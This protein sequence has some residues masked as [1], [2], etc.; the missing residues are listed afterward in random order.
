MIITKMQGAGNDFVIINNM[1]EHL[2]LEG[3]PELARRVCQRR[4]SV[5]ADGMMVV[6]QPSIKDAD[7][8]MI[9]YNADGSLGEMCGNGARCICRYGYEK[10]LAGEIQRVQTTAGIVTGTRI[11][12]RE[13]RVRLNDITVMD[14]HRSL[15]VLGNTY[16]V[17]Y[18]EMG[19]PGIPHA[20][21]HIPG[22]RNLT[23]EQLRPIGKALRW[24]PSFPKGANVNFYDIIGKNE[25]QELTYERGVEDFTYACG[26]GTGSTVSILAKFGVISGKDTLV[27]MPGG[28]LN[29]TTD[30]SGDMPKD[31]MLTGPAVFV[32]EGPL[33]L[34]L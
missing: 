16:D 14:L 11:S 25:L 17:A 30:V 24:H 9:F 27:H 29:V 31:I 5:G 33:L 19:S 34:D 22:L 3:M 7:Y 1:T 12:A 26:T 8:R 15:V 20:V 10:H 23:P 2:P 18:V 32:T 21:V 28:V 4:L 6:E 13:Y